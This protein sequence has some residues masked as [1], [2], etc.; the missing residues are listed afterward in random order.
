MFR[1]QRTT[2]ETINNAIDANATGVH[3]EMHTTIHLPVRWN[4]YDVGP[5][6]GWTRETVTDV[7]FV[8][9][10]DSCPSG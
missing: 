5:E 1:V 10:D 3:R 9:G 2:K 4:H 8:G 6:T 7:Q